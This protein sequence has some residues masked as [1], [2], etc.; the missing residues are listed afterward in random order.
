MLLTGGAGYIGSFVVRELA[1]RGHE[2]LVIDNL[3]SGRAEAIPGAPLVVADIRDEGAVMAAFDRFRPDC[4]IHLAALKSPEESCQDPARYFD[5]N[6]TGT[7]NLLRAAHR[8]QV[9]RFVFSS[10]AAVYGTPQVCPVDETAPA[11]PQSPYGESKYVGERLVASQSAST[12]MRYACLR[13]FNV[14]GA[15]ADA[16]LGE[17]SSTEA[18]QLVPRAVSVARNLLP[19]L[20]VFGVDYPTE[21]GT[22]LRDYIHVMDLARAHVHVAEGLEDAG[23]SGTYNLGRGEGVSV[24]ALVERLRG[25]S[26]AEVALDVA[27]RR[28]GDM[29]ASWADA[30]L[31]RQTFGWHAEYDLHDILSS[32]W[33][34]HTRPAAG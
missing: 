22:A 25:I 4:V 7:V 5:V 10:S 33:A 20:T 13:Y 6:V 34:W 18:R 32:A 9:G 27:P 1:A 28:A 11:A 12:G 8:Y 26:G 2:L 31:V 17:F 21:D 30:G 15:A 3:S 23:R 16:S 19:A 29:A 24:L 14:A